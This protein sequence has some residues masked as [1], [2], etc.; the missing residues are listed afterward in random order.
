MFVTNAASLPF[1]PIVEPVVFCIGPVVIGHEKFVFAMIIIL[2][3]NIDLVSRPS[4]I[5]V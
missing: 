1:S 3:V 4:T 5:R 2:L